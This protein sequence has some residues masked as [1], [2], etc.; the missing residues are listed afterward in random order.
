M[1]FLANYWPLLC[2]ASVTLIYIGLWNIL[3]VGGRADR[4]T[5]AIQAKERSVDDIFRD[6]AYHRRQLVRLQD[7]IVVL[8]GID[9]GDWRRDAIDLRTIVWVNDN[10]KD[11]KESYDRWKRSTGYQPTPLKNGES[12]NAINT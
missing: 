3:L 12:S 11:K 6:A 10:L 7:E 9:L 8:H 5:E 1:D 2:V 4:R